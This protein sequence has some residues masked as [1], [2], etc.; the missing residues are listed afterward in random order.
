MQKIFS[1]IIAI[2]FVTFIILFILFCSKPNPEC[3]EIIL[4]DT[5]SNMTTPTS[6]LPGV[7]GTTTIITTTNNNTTIE[8]TTT[9]LTTSTFIP[10]INLPWVTI[11]GGTFMMGYTQFSDEAPIHTVQ[12][13]SFE[14]LESEVT[15]LQF[16]AFLNAVEQQD[17][18]R[19][20][21]TGGLWSSNSSF[22]TDG[23]MGDEFCGLSRN[24]TGSFYTYSAISSKYS[25]Y[26]VVYVTWTSACEF[27]MW[28]G[29]TLPSEAQWEYAAGGPNHY[30]W[31]LGN[32]FTNTDYCFSTTNTCP[33]KSYSANGFGIY[34]MS[35]GVFEWCYDSFSTY[36]YQSCFNSGT[37]INPINT[38]GSDFVA[39]GGSWFE[40]I[41][42][43]FRVANRHWQGPE[44]K[45]F[46][47]GFRCAR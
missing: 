17:N 31:S 10:P 4:L 2:I 9:P 6:T 44:A 26:P 29:G 8:T 33:V 23:Y 39:R 7:N 16:A 3:D 12:L 13:D 11:P 30:T 5:T 22:R 27:C 41:S 28:I 20:V 25:E 15:T 24:W 45:N 34:D 40:G 21:T 43:H 18:G 42:Y 37:V 46:N 47:L 14:L 38:S 19:Y 36:F 35:G 1:Y 32:T